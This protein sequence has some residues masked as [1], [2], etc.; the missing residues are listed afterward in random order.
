MRWRPGWPERL[1]GTVFP[2]SPAPFAWLS[3]DPSGLQP[4]E[5][6]E[7]LRAANHSSPYLWTTN[8]AALF[9]HLQNVVPGCPYEATGSVSAS[10]RSWV[11]RVPHS[12]KA[13]QSASPW[14]WFHGPWDPL[15][16]GNKNTACLRQGETNHR[17][18]RTHGE[19]Y[20]NHR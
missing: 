12:D 6:R 9:P 15:K 17:A 2:E 8:T 20:R 3:P 16:R 4:S 13:R 10:R 5:S 1:P 11:L 19:A 14:L 18:W 7:C